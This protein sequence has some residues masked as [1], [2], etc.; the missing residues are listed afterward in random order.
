[1]K[2][3]SRLTLTRTILCN[4]YGALRLSPAL[5]SAASKPMQHCYVMQACVPM[6]GCDLHRYIDEMEAEKDF[7][8]LEAEQKAKQEADAASAAAAAGSGEVGLAGAGLG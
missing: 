6:V 3:K 4:L 1:M 8:R 7:E 2:G 5:C